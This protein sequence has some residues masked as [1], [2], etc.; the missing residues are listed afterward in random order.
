[1]SPGHEGLDPALIGELP[2]SLQEAFKAPAQ[3]GKELRRSSLEGQLKVQRGLRAAYEQTALFLPKATDEERARVTKVLG[4][5]MEEI[6]ATAPEPKGMD[7]PQPPGQGRTGGPSQ[8]PKPGAG[9]GQQKQEAKKDA[10]AEEMC[11]TL[12]ER[13]DRRI[14]EL[15]KAIQ[16]L[17]R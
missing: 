16:E 12:I 1:M 15:N 4:I 11:K 14:E 5:A 8:P 2:A 17:G 6:S 10:R 3:A 9:P 13:V 7:M